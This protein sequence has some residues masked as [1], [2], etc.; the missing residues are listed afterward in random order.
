MNDPASVVPI[1]PALNAILNATSGVLL[2]AGFLF[3]KRHAVAAHKACMFGALGVSA[4]FLASY[5]W[6]HAHYGSRPFTGTGW[7]RQVYFAILL[8]HTVLAAAIVPLVFVTVRR[9]LRGDVPGHRR[10]AKITWP[11]WMY[12]SVTGVIVYLL[13]YRLYP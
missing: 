6:Y 3:A 8:S 1:F 2:L 12:V 9:G 11:T 10:I 4:V 5:L 7:I 13:L